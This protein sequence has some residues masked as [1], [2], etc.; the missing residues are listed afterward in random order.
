M[1]EIRDIFNCHC[2]PDHINGAD[3]MDRELTI[4]GFSCWYD[5]FR[6]ADNIAT[7]IQNR[8]VNSKLAILSAIHA[9]LQML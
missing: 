7:E 1:T 6:P 3:W 8:L 9:I 2:C 4:A 5:R